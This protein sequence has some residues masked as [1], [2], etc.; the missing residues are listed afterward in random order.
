MNT[1]KMCATLALALSLGTIQTV[2]AHAASPAPSPTIGSSLVNSHITP[3]PVVLVYLFA[4][5]ECFGGIIWGEGEV[6]DIAGEFLGVLMPN[7]LLV[8]N[9]QV[10]G[11]IVVGV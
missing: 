5:G 1:K 6:Y 10:V 4:E 11:C 9:G 8:N 3:Q 7:G 2:S